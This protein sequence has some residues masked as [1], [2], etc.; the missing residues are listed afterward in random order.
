MP[1]R[2]GLDKVLS[3]FPRWRVEPAGSVEN[4]GTLCVLRRDDGGL[5]VAEFV[6]HRRQLYLY[7]ALGE[8]QSERTLILH[9]AEAWVDLSATGWRRML[10][11]ADRLADELQDAGRPRAGSRGP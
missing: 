2:I 5:L 4:P 8:R 9:P 6:P 7:G 10:A 1:G 11:E 3:E